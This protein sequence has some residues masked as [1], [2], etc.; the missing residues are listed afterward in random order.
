MGQVNPS[1]SIERHVGEHL[2]SNSPDVPDDIAGCRVAVILSHDELNKDHVQ[3]LKKLTVAGTDVVGFAH[4]ELCPLLIG[5]CRH[6]I[7]I[8]WHAVGADSF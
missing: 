7:E 5:N 3:L 6:I 2:I 8:R 4:V 1:N